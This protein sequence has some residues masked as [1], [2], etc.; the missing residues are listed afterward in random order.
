M[1]NALP[2]AV[3]PQFTSVQI[4][5][6][7][8]LGLFLTVTCATRTVSAESIRRQAATAGA[9]RFRRRAGARSSLR[10]IVARD[11]HDALPLGE[12]DLHHHHVLLAER[13]FGSREIELPH[14]HEA[15]VVNALHLLAVGEKPLAPSFE[16]FGIMQAQDFDVGDKQPG[17]SRSP[18]GPPTGQGCSRRGKYISRS[19]DW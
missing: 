1:D 3:I 15:L 19:R 14:A 16:R 7:V 5:R 11:R 4:E 8:R 10:N 18:A 6:W 9:A 2:R 17:A 12:L 13:H